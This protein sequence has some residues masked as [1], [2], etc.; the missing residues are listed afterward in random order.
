[1][2]GLFKRRKLAQ[3]LARIGSCVDTS[4]LLYVNNEDAMSFHSYDDALSYL[5]SFRS[6]NII[7]KLQIFRIET[8]SL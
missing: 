4:Y 5:K 2:I 7:Y 6:D 3:R 1:M 8:Y